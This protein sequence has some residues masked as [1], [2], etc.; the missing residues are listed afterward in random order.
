MNKAIYLLLWYFSFDDFEK[1]INKA[2]IEGNKI[3]DERI[4][5]FINIRLVMLAIKKILKALQMRIDIYTH[6]EI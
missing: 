6:F 5:K 3:K 4:G 2:P 1:N